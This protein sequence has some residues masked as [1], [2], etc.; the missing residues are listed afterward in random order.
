MRQKLLLLRAIEDSDI[1]LLSKWLYKDYILKWYHEPEEWLYEM[2]ERKGAFSFLSHF[3]VLQENIPLGFCQ[4]YDCFDAQEEWYSVEN[5]G[6]IYSIDYL[7]GDETYLGKGYGK[8]IVKMLI[9]KIVEEK[10]PEAIVVQ[11][12]NENIASCKA[13]EANGF[14]YDAD[15]EYYI[16][17]F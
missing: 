2:K 15:K 16:L 12:E 17:R 8:E 3:L 11:P 10:N 9:Q 5:P 1:E 13:L 14:V 6:K 7:I 4:Y